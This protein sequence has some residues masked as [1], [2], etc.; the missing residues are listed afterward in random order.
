[1]KL[2]GACALAALW[3]A[4]S[5]AAAAVPELSL[6]QGRQ[7]VDLVPHMVAERIPGHAP[8]DPEVLWGGAGGAPVEPAARWN[9]EA[10]DSWLGRITLRGSR[11]RDMYVLQVP[12]PQVDRV[13]VWYRR[14]GGEWKSAQAGDR[15]AMSR[16]PFPSP[17]PAFPIPMRG[18]PVDVVVLVANE[19]RLLVPVDLL[20]DELFR[21]NQVRRAGVSGLM[22]GLG[23]MVLVV[24]LIGALL[25]RRRSHWLL[26]GVASWGLLAI[27]LNNGY[28]P[29][30]LPFD[31]PMLH[32]RGRHF[33]WSVLAGFVVALVLTALDP[34]S[35]SAGERR[36]GWLYAI[37]GI[38]YST[39]QLLW[40]PTDWRPYGGGAWGVFAMGSCALLAGVSALRGGRYVPWV[41]AAIACFSLV[42]FANF[43]PPDLVPGFDYR[44]MTMAVAVCAG[45]LLLRHV[46]VARD[47]HGRDV[48]GRAAISAYRDPLTAL[49]SPLGF[50]HAWE[51]V[52]LRQQAGSRRSAV[53]L[54][55]L[56]GLASAAA[57]H[58]FVLAE[59]GLV[60]V[61][62]AL[63]AALGNGWTIARLGEGHFAALRS[64]LAD[65][66]EVQ[67]DA[68]RLLAR[69]VRLTQ[70]F[71]LVAMFDLRIACAHGTLQPDGAPPLVGALREAALAL[72]PGKRIACV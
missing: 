54:I 67:S 8:P 63:H 64:G 4:A 14:Q 62:A 11:E 70:P 29:V 27:L 48:L 60:R 31:A 20:P 71:P 65:I 1:M 50:E 56:P 68:T 12:A 58:G 72:E 13:Q 69:M 24:C 32:D 55:E 44:A 15:V 46:L 18:E 36:L 28:L 40:L 6:T 23:A 21:A 38:A 35:L 10:G 51:E 17:F 7:P 52:L 66:D 19:G 26:A 9:V 37:G 3:F 53:L 33:F 22:A 42:I 41:G 39:A 45:L 25:L 49:L 5:L 2:F 61:A 57:E 34:Q 16:W 59:R 43:L 30:W 47:R